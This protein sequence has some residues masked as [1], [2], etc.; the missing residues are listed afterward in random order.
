MTRFQKISLFLLRIS[1]GWM[2]FYAGITKVI[3]P[4]WSAGGY[5]KGAKTFV[6]AYQW[7]A[8]PNIL[9]LVN[10]VN[11]WG[12]TLLGLSLIFGIFVRLGSI[13][14]AVLMLLYY[15]PILDFPY[16]NPHSYLVDEHIIY[17]FVLLLLTSL[18]A[19]RVWGLE[20]WCSNLPIC[21]KYPKLRA[22]LG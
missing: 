2:M 8:S 17:I 14:G 15:I 5:L 3:D 4:T 16:P 7:L 13:L 6:G 12:L 11:E 18:R 19:G 9:P 1:M 10:F 22:W 21:S 20:N